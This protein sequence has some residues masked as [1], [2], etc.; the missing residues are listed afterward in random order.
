[1]NEPALEVREVSKRFA[2]TEAVRGVS[3][4]VAAGEVLALLGPN[5]AGKSTTLRLIS[6]LAHPDSGTVN[7][8]GK[9]LATQR[10][11]ALSHAGF[12][13]ES[14]A[15]PPELTCRAA[16]HYVGLLGGGVARERIDEVLRQVGLADAAN[17]PFRQCSLGMRQ[18]LGIGA[19]ILRKPK[20]AVLDE[21]LN[22]LDPAGIREMSDLMR[23]LAAD[24]TAVLLSSH[25]LDEVERTA[26]RVVVLDKGSVVASAPV[27]S[28]KAGAVADLF[29]R[30]TQK[31]AA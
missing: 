7:I 29:F 25:L 12:L 31:G 23:T 14:P 28:G 18:R 30:L 13:V 4:Q 9:S 1:M 2:T 27:E 8:G 20:L 3:F 10:A 17:K 16:L 21:P 26:H 6:G 5:G 11:A 22:G 19:V 24:G 15:F